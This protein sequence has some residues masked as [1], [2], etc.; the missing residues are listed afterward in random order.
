MDQRAAT[1]TEDAS[2]RDQQDLKALGLPVLAN[3]VRTSDLGIALLDGDRRWLYVNPA[4]CRILGA[5]L[6]E[7]IGRTAPFVAAEEVHH[8][9]PVRP[10]EQRTRLADVASR[11]RRQR[12]PWSTPRTASS[13]GRSRGSR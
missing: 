9:E 2:D 5:D 6:G 3:L 4:G 13:M 12:W 10:G 8:D 11:R 1:Q 7:L